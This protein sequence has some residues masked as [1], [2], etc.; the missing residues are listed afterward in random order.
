MHGLMP[1]LKAC[2]LFFVL[3]LFQVSDIYSQS[4]GDPEEGKI[5]F[6]FT[7]IAC[8]T[9][10]EGDRL[11]PDL[12]NVTEIRDRDWIIRK[13]N[14]PY[15]M[16]D[17][18]D[19]ITMQNIEKFGEAMAPQGLSQQEILN[20]VAYLEE[21]GVDESAL[22]DPSSGGNF[23]I[24]AIIAIGILLLSFFGFKVIRK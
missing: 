15:A 5:L 7:C 20:V 24:I 13:I 14:D 23:L 2:F 11:G 18:G 19:P 16:R 10:G 9:V 6:S 12:L 17:E 22:D 21:Y 1:S 3:I 8:H 4:S